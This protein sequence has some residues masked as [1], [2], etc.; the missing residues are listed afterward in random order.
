MGKYIDQ[1]R[2][3]QA[4]SRPDWYMELYPEFLKL[5][6]QAAK[7]TAK[8]RKKIKQAAYSLTEEALATDKIIVGTAGF[9]F[10]VERQPIDTILIHHTNNPAGMS[11]SRLNAIHLLRLYAARYYS[12]KYQPDLRGQPIWSGHFKNRQQV[13]WGYHWLIRADGSKQRLLDDKLI[14]WHAGDW[15]INRRSLAI[16]IDDDLSDSQP[17][18]VVLNSVADLI[19]DRYPQVAKRAII[20]QCQ[21]NPDISNP[22]SLFVSVWRDKLLK[23]INA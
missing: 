8:D 2:W 4:F 18:P 11:L 17:S 7:S 15:Q 9:D 6:Q 10:D 13:F 22:G 21:L 19:N 16:C 5:Q 14:A 3:L 12:T 1:Q 23:Q 20:G